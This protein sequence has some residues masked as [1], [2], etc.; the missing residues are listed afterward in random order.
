[1]KYLLTPLLIAGLF[2]SFSAALVSMLFYTD[3]VDSPQELVSLLT[4]AED[5]SGLPDD[6][7]DQEDKLTTML[8]LVEG[9]RQE[10]EAQ[11]DSL[12]AARNSLALTTAQ[13]VELRGA[14]QEELAARESTGDSAA[15]LR[16]R[17]QGSVLAPAFSKIKPDDAAA[18]LAEGSLSDTLVAHL[19]FELQPQQVARIMGSMD[20]TY[21]ARI[22][23]MMGDLS[24]P[25]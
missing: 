18:I 17:Q 15:F 22:T 3:V 2:L 23:R 13:V 19:M 12:N 10:Y 7:M 16:A 11:L 4:G 9:Y 14:L 5:Q 20:V 25:Q 1:V 21:A 8:A 6:L 24:V